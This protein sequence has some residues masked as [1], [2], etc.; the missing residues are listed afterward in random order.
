MSKF[1]SSE[2]LIV[3]HSVRCW[4]GVDKGK[5]KG[6]RLHKATRRAEQD[7]WHVTEHVQIS[8]REACKMYFR[9]ASIHASTN[10]YDLRDFR[11][12]SQVIQDSSSFEMVA[13][14]KKSDNV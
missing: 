3:V 2:E 5:V 12:V 6:W 7:T 10:L 11:D 1:S 13:G 8:I 14:G 9:A 4:V